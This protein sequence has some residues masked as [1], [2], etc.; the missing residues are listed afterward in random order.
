MRNF[1]AIVCPIHN[2]KLDNDEIFNLITTNL[3]NPHIDKYF[4]LP[5]N[6]S[7]KNHLK[8]KLP[9]FSQIYID[10]ENFKSTKSY[11]DLLLSTKIYKIFYKYKYLVICQ[12]DAVI[13]KNLNYLKSKIIKY[14]YVGAPWLKPYHFNYF[15]LKELKYLRNIVSFFKINKLFV[16]NGGLSIRRTKKFYEFFKKN[17]IRLKRNIPEDIAISYFGKKNFF[18]IPDVKFAKK[19][20]SETFKDE[21]LNCYGYHALKIWSPN[22]Q[23]K[24]YKKFN[25]I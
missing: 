2:K 17:K 13:I 22:T 19:I 1:F 8:R 23:K 6:Y 15:E 18:S 11:N 4:L 12:S 9:F 7:F 25:L 24:I 21:N 16:G 10:G 14:D 5:I 20:F 3:S